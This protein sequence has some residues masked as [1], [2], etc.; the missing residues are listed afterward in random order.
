MVMVRVMIALL[1]KL[2]GV[3]IQACHV[4]DHLYRVHLIIINLH[5]KFRSWSVGQVVFQISCSLDERFKD[6]HHTLHGL[7]AS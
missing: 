6:F 7:N 4:H 3:H 1:I 2:I 5:R